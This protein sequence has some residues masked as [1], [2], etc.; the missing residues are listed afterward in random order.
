MHEKDCD[1]SFMRMDRQLALLKLNRGRHSA[2]W[3]MRMDKD[4]PVEIEGPIAYIKDT[5]TAQL[6]SCQ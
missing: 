2:L 1:K 4:S 6:N 5:A 3:N